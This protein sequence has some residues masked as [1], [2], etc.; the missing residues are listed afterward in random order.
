MK[1][2]AFVLLVGC[3]VADHPELSHGADAGTGLDAGGGDVFN[4]APARA[5]SAASNSPDA[6]PGNP[7]AHTPTSITLTQVSTDTLAAASLGC[8]V[9]GDT[10]QQAYYRVFDL[11]SFGVTGPLSLSSIAFG[12]QSVSGTQTIT[13][14]AG[15][16]SA[17]PGSTLDVGGTDWGAG[18]VTPLAATTTSVTASASGTVVSVPIAATV[19]ATARL[20]VEIESPDD[21][22][23]SNSSFFLGASSGAETSPGFYWAPGCDAAPPGT[24]SSLGQGVV[25]FVITA[26][27]TY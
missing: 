16:Y 6:A 19:P 3:A 8:G 14:R 7:D 23:K 1:T 21:S 25:P 12:V 10:D 15:T 5:D 2:L 20:I 24:P 13:V 4:D 9:D 27:G 11:A 17:T 22:S 26:T 18:D